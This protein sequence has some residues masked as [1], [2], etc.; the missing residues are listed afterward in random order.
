MSASTLFLLSLFIFFH[1][2]SS[3]CRWAPCCMEGF[4]SPANAFW[5][6]YTS[7]FMAQIYKVVQR[8]AR[9]GLKMMKNPSI[10]W[11]WIIIWL[12]YNFQYLKNFKFK[13]IMK[14]QKIKKPWKCFFLRFDFFSRYDMNMIFN[15]FKKLFKNYSKFWILYNFLIWYFKQYD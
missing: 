8:R 3:P 5:L 13:K 9:N 11:S 2:S 6:S 1:R 10:T 15:D 14:I 4:F 7:R 12:V